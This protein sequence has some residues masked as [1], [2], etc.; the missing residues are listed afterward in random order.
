VD[1]IN[2]YVKS[3]IGDLDAT[4]RKKLAEEMTINERTIRNW[5]EGRVKCPKYLMYIDW[6]KLLKKIN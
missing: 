3:K 4:A 5:T 2:S 1:A 6:P